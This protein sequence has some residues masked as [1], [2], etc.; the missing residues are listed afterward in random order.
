VDATEQ[1]MLLYQ[2][3]EWESSDDTCEQPVIIHSL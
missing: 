3:L 1:G 2:N